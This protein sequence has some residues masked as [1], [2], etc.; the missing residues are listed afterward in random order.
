MIRMYLHTARYRSVAR[1]MVRN[2]VQDI[3]MFFRGYLNIKFKLVS[4]GLG[5][6]L[7]CL[8]TRYRGTARRRAPAER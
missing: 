1:L 6:F 8:F 4:S 2:V 5:I 7:K 3:R